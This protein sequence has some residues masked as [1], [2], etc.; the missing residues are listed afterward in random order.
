MVQP[1]LID[2]GLQ[3]SGGIEVSLDD[4]V[5]QP[6]TSAE[7]RLEEIFGHLGDLSQEL[8]ASD[9]L[10][11]N[12]S[13]DEGSLPPADSPEFEPLV[14]DAQEAVVSSEEPPRAPEPNPRPQVEEELWAAS[15]GQSISTADQL[16]DTLRAANGP[17]DSGEPAD[18]TWVLKNGEIL[19]GYGSPR[20]NLI[21]EAGIVSPGNSP[22][23]FDVDN[24]TQGAEGTQQIEITGWNATNTPVVYDQFIA[25]GNVTLDGT[26]K[27][28]LSGFTPAAGQTFSIM[29]WGGVRV[30]EFANYLGTTVP[31]NDQLAL[32]PEYDDGAKELRLRV[33]DTESVA[34][35]VERALRDV[36]ELAG[37]LLNLSA[38]GATSLPLIGS[39]IQDVLDAKQMVED[40]IQQ[41]ILN[42]VDGL[43]T[44]AQVTKE[45]EGLEGQTFGNFT[46]QVKSVLGQYSQPAAPNIFYAW[47]VKI[48]L[49]ET[50]L[51]ALLS[52]G[53]NSV[54]DFL[55]G[56][57]SQLTL[58]NTLELDFTFGYDDNDGDV[59]T[60]NAFVDLRSITPRTKAIASNLNPLQLTPAWLLSN[61]LT[62]I[63]ATATV[64]FEAWIQFAP[65]PNTFPG[66]H[67][68]STQPM[69]LPSFANFDQTEGSSLD[70][71]IVLNASVNDPNN[72]WAPFTF[73]KY[74]GQH[75]LHIVDT[76]LFDSVDPDVTLTV[77]GDLLVFGQK[78]T[79]VFTFFKAG[80]STDIAIDADI[81]NLDLKLT[82]GIGPELRILKATGTGNFLLK[83]NGDLAGV[84]SLTIAPGN[85]PELPNIDDLSGTFSLTFNGA[86]T[87]ITVPLPN[88]QSVIVPGGG[89]YYRIDGQNVTLDIGI[90]DIVLHADKFTFEPIDSTPANPNDD[91]QEIV[92]AV[93]GLS[94]DFTLPGDNTL[95][96]LTDGAGIL[97]LTRIG[98]E[99]GMVAQITSA[100]V[101]VDIFGIAGLTGQ[102]SAA[103]NDFTQAVNRQLNVLGQA[104][105][106][107][108]AA[109]KLLR[110]EATGAELSLLAGQIGDALQISGNFAFE[111][112]EDA[113]GKIVT[114]AFSQGH[115]PFLDGGAQQV[116]VLDNISGVF[117]SNEKG[118][119]GQAT[120]GTFQFGVP[121]I[122]FT[123]NPQSDISLQI[124]TTDE[125]VQ[126]TI[127]LG[128]QPV[129]L[130]VDTGPFIRFRMLQVN[131]TIAGFDVI[132]GDF[133]FE[134]RQS[135]SGQQMITVAAR[136]V[137]FNLGP[138][139]SILDIRDGNGLFVISG[140]QFAGAA[141]VIVDVAQAPW[142]TIDDGDPDPGIK[143]TF[144]FNNSTQAAIDQVF[145]FSGASFSGA[146]GGQQN[147]FNASSK[148]IGLAHARPGLAQPPQNVPVPG[149]GLVPLQVPA[150]EFFEV[151]G[152]I[153]LSFGAGGG[154]QTL[155]GVFAFTNVDSGGQKF[156]GVKAEDL[157]LQLK[158]GGTEVIAFRDG[159]GQFAL[160]N[161]GLGGTAS[162]DFELGIVNVGGSITLEVDS[163]NHPILAT[164]GGYNINLTET[165][166]L[167]VYVDG[168]IA[169]GPGSFPFDFDIEVDFVTNEV[170]FRQTGQPPAQFLVKVDA[171]GNIIFGTLPALP[172]FPQVGEGEFLPL[173]K[174]LINWLD[175]FRNSSVFDVGIPFTGGTTLGDAFDYAQW[176]ITNVYPEVASVEL[177]S[178]AS[179]RDVVGNPLPVGQL[180]LSGSYG[181]FTI[182]LEIGEDDPVAVNVPANTYTSAAQLATRLHSAVNPA[183]GGRVVGRLNKEGQP[184]L[185]LSDAEIAKH[186]TLILTFA[187]ANHP[188]T[189]LGFSNNQRAIEVERAAL[190]DM[191]QAVGQALGLSPPP[192]DPN[193]KVVTL[194]VNLNHNLPV[195][196]LPLDFG[197]SLGLIAEAT[198]TGNLAA[199]VNLKL[200]MTLGFDFS[201]VEVPIVLTSPLVPVPANGRL[202]ANAHFD[203]FLNGDPSPIGI[204]LIAAETAGFT[205]MEHLVNY[206][207]GKLAAKSYLG[208]PLDK[209]I[210][211]RK[212]DQ[213]I[214]LM[215]LQEDK[216]GDKHF[217]KA[218][219]DVNE[220]NQ[221][222][223]GEDL[224]GD[225][226]LDLNED[227][228]NNF[229]LDLGEDIDGDG[230][231]DRGED[232]NGDNAFQNRLGVINL[233]VVAA[234]ANN[235][236]ATELG[237][238]T[239]P[240]DVGGVSYLV[241]SAKS[242]LKGLFLDTPHFEATMTVSG[243]ATGKLRIGFLE[244]NVQPGTG[245]NTAPPIKVE[246]DIKNPNTGQTRFYIPELMNGLASLGNLVADLEVTGGVSAQLKLGLDPALGILL[247]SNAN[248]GILIPDIKD[249]SFNPEPYAPGKTGIFLTYTGLNG[250][251]SFSDV[252]FQ[253]ILQA[254]RA[255]VE[256]LSQL[257]GFGF[258]NEEIPFIEVSLADMLKWAEKVADLV[259]GLT[260]G[261][262]KSLQKMLSILQAEIESL[263]HINGRN[264]NIFSLIVDDVPNPLP[265]VVSGNVEATFNPAGGNNGLKF[266]SAGTSLSNA[267]IKI[268]GSSEASGG[269]AL[270]SWDATNQILTIKIDSGVTTA[271]AI[272]AALG[273]L[274]S[275]WTASLTEGGGTGLVNR[276]AIKVHLN[277]TTGF[278]HSVPLQINLQKLLG[279]L[280]GDNT[281]AHEFLSQAT[282]FIHLEGDGLLSV[283][284]SAGVVLD[285]GLDLTNPT[286]IKP[287]LYD[288]TKGS[289]KLEVIGT[290]LEFEA[291][292]GSV[293]GIFVR[294]G[295]VTL[296]ADGD[297]DTQG[298]AEIALGFKDNNGDGRHYFSE[299]LFDSESFGF[300]ARAGLTADLPV[301]A[302]TEGT[303]L[304]SD[305]D[306]N[307]DDYPDNHL[308]VDIPDLVRLFIPD[309]ANSPTATIEMR[310]NHNDFVVTSTDEAKDKFKV[311]FVHNP[312]APP[313]AQYAPG[314]NTLTL[315]INSGTTTANQILAEIATVPTFSAALTADDD[316]N[317][318][319][320]GNTGL[321]RL[322]KTTIATPDFSQLFSNLD[323]CAIIDQNAG[324]LL[325]GLD[326]A[327]GF[328]QDGLDDAVA[329]VDLP[330]IGDGLQGTANFIEDFREGLL[331][332]LRTA[333][334]QNGGSATET[335]KNAL[336][337][338]VWNVLGKPGADLLVDPV[339][340][341][342]LDTYQQIDI[343]LD[344][345]NGLQFNLRLHKALFAFDTGDALDID[346]G[347]PGFG[348]ELSGNLQLQLAFDF[349]LGFGLNKKDGFYFVTSAQP[350]LSQVN[351]DDV[352]SSAMGT[353]AE[354]FLGFSIVPQLAGSA[355]LFFLQLDVEDMGSFFRG[356]FEIDLKDP[357]N[358]GKLTFAELSSPGLSFGKVFVPRLGAVANV[359]LHAALS[360]GGSA[361]F[362]R[363]LANFHLD[364]SWDLEKG[365]DGPHINFDEI[366]LDLGSYIS[367]FLGPVLGKIREFTAPAD[368]ILD[369]VTEP[370]PII[371]DLLGEP[372]TFL[373]LAEAFGYLDPG[374]RKFIEV[375]AQV[376]DVIQLV[377]NFDGKSL[378]IPMG[379]FEMIAGI[380]NE[381]PRINPTGKL[382]NN[383]EQD[384]DSIKNANPGAG[385]TE[386]SQTVGFTGK[387]DASVF[388]F[389]IWEN[390]T[391]IFQ[392][393]IGAPVR[394][395]EVRLPT[396]RFEFTY[397]Q[398]IPIYGP[399]FAR[400]G[401]T[402]GAELTFGF[403]YD[404]FG[405]QKYISSEDK[406]VADIFDGFYI[407]DF[408]EAG[409]ERPEIRLFGEIFA[410]AQIDLGVA[411]AGVEGGVRVTVDFDLND[412]NDDGRIR[413]SE[414]IALAE[415][416]P[417]CLF[418]IHGTVDLFLRA[419]L[420]VNL[421]L[422]SIDAEWEFATITLF[423]FEFTCQLPEP[424]SQNGSVLTLHIGDDADQRKQLD[425]TDGAERFIVKHI[426]DDPGGETVEVNWEGF[427]EEFNGVQT[428]KVVNA[429]KGNDYID[430]RG[431][432]AA[433]DIKLGEG[434]DTILLGDG[435][436]KIDG[437]DG[438]DTITG[439]GAGLE[440]RGGAGRDTIVV[441]GTA[442]VY[443]DDG[444]DDITGSDGPDTIYGG[445]GNDR[446]VSGLDNDT[447]E[448]GSG[449][450]FIEAGLGDDTVRGDDGADEIRLGDGHDVAYGGN[451]D[452][453]ILGG[454]GN[455]V[456]IGGNGDDQLFGHSGVDLLVG[457]TV[458][459]WSP[460]PLPDFPQ[461]GVTVTGIGFEDLPAI[462]DP[463]QPTASHDDFLIGGGNYDFIFGGQGNDFIFGGN[464]FVSGQSEVIEEDDNDMMDGGTGDDE[465]FGDD[466]Q[467]KTGDRDTGIAVRSVVW[468]DQN[469]NHIRDEGEPGAAGVTVEIFTPSDP[470][471]TDKAVTKEDGSFKFTGLDPE[472][473]FLVFTSPY[474]PATQKGLRL[475]TPNLSENEAIDSDA[476]INKPELALL[477]KPVG[478]ANIGMT[479]TFTLHV[480]ETLTTVNAGV[481]GQ[482]VLSIQQDASASEG[483]TGTSPLN[484]T[485]NLSRAV[486]APVTVRF[487]TLDGTAK[488]VGAD[489]DY[490]GVN[491]VVTF[492]PGEKTKTVSIA[493]VG[494][495]VYE[496]RYEQFQ[497][498]LDQINAPANDPVY[499]TNGGQVSLSTTGTIIGD[500]GPPELSVSDYVPEDKGS[501][502]VQENTPATF[503]VRLSNPSADV[504]TVNWKTVDS[505]AFEAEGQAHYA[506][507]GTDYQP[508]GGALIFAPG[509]T[510]KTIGVNLLQDA[511]DE[512]EE[513][514]FVQLFNAHNALL[515]DNH[516]V[517]IIADD[518]GPVRVS[519]VLDPPNQV[520]GLPNTT[521]VF[522]GETALFK[523]RLSTASEKDVY[524]SY[525]SS[526]GTAVTALPLEVIFFTDQRP[527][528]ISAPDPSAQPAQQRLH[529]KPGET[530]KLLLVNTL[531]QD[532]APEPLE[533]FFLNLLTADNGVIA[534]NHGVIR[535]KDLDTGSGDAGISPI[536][537][538]KTHFYVH[539]YEPFAEITLVRSA[540]ST[541][542]TGVFFTQDVTATN[543]Q[544]Y[545]GGTY[546]VTFAPQEFVKTVQIPIQQDQVWEGDEDVK[547]SIRG[548]TGKAANAA[549]YVATLTILDDED[550]P[551]V[552]IS[553]PT[554]EVTEGNNVKAVFHLYSVVQA[555][556]IKIHYKTVD[557]TAF[558]GLDYTAQNSSVTLNVIVD[559]G[560]EGAIE[561]PILNNPALEAP[562]SFGLLLTGIEHGKLMQTKGTVIIRDDE[563]DTIEGYVFLDVN[564]NRFFDEF[565]E[566]GLKD[567][568]VAITDEDNNLFEFAVTDETGKYTA[569]A[570]QGRVSVKVLESSLT[571]KDPNQSKLKFYTGFELTTDNDSQTIE[572]LGGSGL[573]LFE[574][575][576]YQPKRLN[577]GRVD[578]PEPVG[579][580]G[581]D[582][583]LFG[584][585]G[586][587]FID[588]GAGDDHVVGGHWQTATNHWAP[589]NQ[590]SYDAKVKALFP[591]GSPDYT[592]LRPLNGLIFDVDTVG[593]GNNSTVSGSVLVSNNSLLLPY[594]GMN[595][596]LLDDKGNVVDTVKTTS[597]F[598]S[599]YTFDG[600]FPGK[601]Q[602]EFG[603]PEGYSASASVDPDTFRSPVFDLDD[604]AA[605]PDFSLNVTIQA[606]P[607]LPTSEQ[608]IFHKPT[609]IVAQGEQDSFAVVKLVRGEAGKREAVAV[610]T[611]ELN[612]PDAAQEN[613]HYKPIR[614]VVNFEIGQ[615]ERTVVVPILADG[616]IPECE[617]VELG[618]NLYAATGELLSNA[619]MFIQDVAGAIEDNDTIRGGDDWDII[620][621][622][623]G[624][625]P[626]HLHPG[627]FLDPAPGDPNPPPVLDPYLAIKFSGGPGEDSIDAGRNIDRVFGQGGEDFIDG[628]YGTDIIDAGLGNDLIAVSW[629][630][631]IVEGNF[632]RD[633]LEGT[634]DA[635]HLVEQGTG[636]GGE[637]LLKFDLPGVN[638]DTTITFTG[639]EHVK[640][641]GGVGNNHFTLTNWGGSAE[642]LGFFGADQLIV[643]NN[644]DMTLKDGIMEQLTLSSPVAK[645]ILPSVSTQAE[646]EDNPTKTVILG[647][648][649]SAPL[650]KLVGTSKAKTELGFLAAAKFIN[651]QPRASLT[652]G[653]GSLYTMTGVES[654][655]LI[656][657]PS[658][659]TLDAAQYSGN[660]IFQ[661]LGGDD[662]LLGGDGDDTFL[663]T[664]ADSGTDTVV[665]NAD[666]ASAANDQGF[667]TLDF[668]ALTQNLK[669]DLHILNA[670]QQIWTSG[671]LSLIFGDEDLDAILGGSGHD[672]LIGNARDNLLLGGIGN[673]RL[674][675]REGTE[676][677][678]FDA[679]LVWGTETVVED[680][681]D[682]SGHDVLDFSRTGSFAVV[683]DLNS[684][685]PQS[686]GNLT[687]VLGAGGFEEVIGGSLGDTLTGN[688]LD[689][690]LRGGPG[691]DTLFGLGGN[692]ILVGGPGFD[693]MIG[694][695][696]T[697]RLE[698]QANTHFTLNDSNLFKGDGDI[699]AL[700]SVED[701]HLTG[702]SS[703]NTFNLTGW[704]GQATLDAGGHVADRF[705]MQA[706]ADFDLLDLN[707]DDVRLEL[708]HPVTDGVADQTIDLIGFE[709]FELTGGETVDVLD[710]SALTANSDGQP[711]GAFT[712]AG[713]GGNDELHGTLWDDV[714]RGGPGND[715]L[716]GNTGN[717]DIDGGAGTDTLLIVRDAPLFLLLNSSILIDE[718]PL[719]DGS[720]LD[721]ITS[722][723]NLS[724]V[725]GPS[726]NIF[727]ASGWTGGTITVDGGGHTAG[728]TIKAAGDA[729]FTVTDSSI[730]IN[731]A[732]GIALTNIERAE[733]T[734]GPGDNI[735]DAS[736]FSGAVLMSGL[737]GNDELVAGTGTSILFGGDGDDILISGPG[738]TGIQGGQGDDTYIF[739]ADSPLGLDIIAD[740]GGTD[741]L[742]FSLTETVGI[743]LQLGNAAA[744][745]LNP[746]L[747]LQLLGA[748]PAFE[749]VIGTR[750]ADTITGNDLANRLE[751][752][753]GI[754]QLNG[755]NG[756]D[757]LVGGAGNDILAGGADNDTFEFDA[758]SPLGADQVSDSGGND[759]LDFSPTQGQSI[760]VTLVSTGVPQPVNANLSLTI[761]AGVQIE[762]VIGGN[763]ADNLTGNNLPNLIRGGLGEDIIDG[764]TGIDTIFETRDADF[765]LSNTQLRIGAEL[766]DLVSIEQAFLIG[767]AGDNIFDAG[768]FTLG[769]VGLSGLGGNDDLVGGSGADILLGG[770]G[771]DI[772]EGR[773]G[774]DVM[775]GGA[776]HDRYLFNLATPLG[777]DIIAELANGGADTLVGIQP[778]AINL[779]LN[780][781]QVISPN[782]TLT[783][784]NL[785]VENLEP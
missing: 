54:F 447:V 412:F 594:P 208:A 145:D 207:N 749:N 315:T 112:H 558:A 62:N 759:T 2:D 580:G 146:S 314:T 172:Q 114:V 768:T 253:Q 47:D 595:V 298:K 290:D 735:L 374:T 424:A 522:E 563:Q 582:D 648:A 239:D 113:N 727:D 81:S 566:R 502:P 209:W 67:W 95:L 149:D 137:E 513:R 261:N 454:S 466:A 259:D 421:L 102:F 275:P 537:F 352:S 754:D 742:D 155:S 335:I 477:G 442:T 115:L 771:D 57:G 659:N 638:F 15:H 351:T 189:A 527:D 529:F 521:E 701:A 519:L 746:N 676:T 661:G 358:D 782:L 556:D 570:S 371:S 757:V 107:S 211:A 508:A 318:N 391:E 590:G 770:D 201:A 226:R 214:A 230:L 168:F 237:I 420:R 683:L 130:N 634:R 199:T 496:G 401:G 461:D 510:E 498:L 84:A 628:G 88:D 44:Q 221:L 73:A 555:F 227:A 720:E 764:G 415:I 410:G 289:L 173:I 166:Y 564:G 134:Q 674:E 217:D 429:G 471:F 630:D 365:Q 53:L 675:G 121:A 245:F 150:G 321:G 730:T 417:L 13:T 105:T 687:L 491:T 493:L 706:A 376:V 532:T 157:T 110:V 602:L 702:G 665:G 714:L 395:I 600:V 357:N 677:Y 11:P 681:N 265:Q 90:P 1:S 419:F 118:L 753:A 655:H 452:D 784:Q 50:E 284:A 457:D 643:D 111:Q 269:L 612:G 709:L 647:T 406:N 103:I 236:A 443:G 760:T 194:P 469:G 777:A 453:L 25:S 273:T 604:T 38:P 276:T 752:G 242:S 743:V 669:V 213:S 605:N 615:Y 464:F 678:A 663:Y 17:P 251:E 206:I 692:D 390:P 196:N 517:G 671:P 258:L 337:Q 331:A 233:I 370:L 557:L 3:S 618:L 109:G 361:A 249:L 353:T 501:A 184:V 448:G 360:F 499:F 525:G 347:V 135:E 48:V 133:G 649:S 435:G 278:G 138:V 430:L 724:V 89:P 744:Q 170:I 309:Q 218:N 767:G 167:R 49:K 244:V 494:D 272:V 247:P 368:P 486:K 553:E 402:V 86:N 696:G 629:G 55:F 192:Y 538:A 398:K 260:S 455:D 500:D 79:G 543:G 85:G 212:A 271:N 633:V 80:A 779:A 680:P 41:E 603:V 745:V 585:P 333:I 495:P 690:T 220:N 187:G 99:S 231:L 66:G 297:P 738:N 180:P 291:S 341:A 312:A 241:S 65:N 776:G 76:D 266:S 413:I 142:L 586:N 178:V 151:K 524:V 733:L 158:A 773:G 366:Y 78:L 268:L 34:V 504:V 725:G 483:E 668:T 573:E 197:E 56:A 215:A 274:G 515:A 465:L 232:L 431:T 117:V 77:D 460:K 721:T 119:A 601:Y 156:V 748:T 94:F 70:A 219:E 300:T 484:V 422:F 728:D 542:A 254:L 188:M 222:D 71:T 697:D 24:Y 731:G 203:L 624:Y 712:L 310:G 348:L 534:Q 392:L 185:A 28:A 204:D 536:S 123:T 589:I 100:Q 547:L 52:S 587:D 488:S 19:G 63:S 512:Y 478:Q 653:N 597:A 303:P 762:N 432:T 400:F 781:A 658:A 607:Q 6:A 425:T 637:D 127:S 684:G 350:N 147:G 18:A 338:V 614:V 528:F 16:T 672:D 673:D 481:V 22:G 698:E 325:D 256:M 26:L 473:Y 596:N 705:I 468:L 723:E 255:V 437:G 116:L 463:G 505:A 506:T 688:G 344:C 246:L 588:A 408:D 439:G 238:G 224:D 632:D 228:N 120:V 152:P 682:P 125:P 485:L 533:T 650:S 761:P 490:V 559:G 195:L 708:D 283:A 574:P 82:V 446:I 467:G 311:V 654:S 336:K 69:N 766:D 550:V 387:L 535:V 739:D 611:E 159:V 29:Q 626:K 785:N 625:I 257:Q 475:V 565:T 101:D 571:V 327:L 124:N 734:G 561:I 136:D 450:D 606:G 128:G 313:D 229:M 703:A 183:T 323:L 306:A 635:D 163:T 691:N 662:Q 736:Q 179:F 286:G 45:I 560:S 518:D 470:T 140:G 686:I 281:A 198:L 440:I 379:A 772:L 456:L 619:R 277:F 104:K 296:D 660:V 98:N 343:Q 381:T 51:T 380:G 93:E 32:V 620:L 642:I 328:I 539:E 4:P 330:L 58:E 482:V 165:N 340:G 8:P 139:S 141:E 487:R 388:H 636:P 132:T 234:Q 459:N 710:G 591:E 359:D 656:G 262:P 621:G 664:A 641:L 554:I 715:T 20:L 97:L 383:F 497:I 293:V 722:V 441:F 700:E 31:G 160:F 404:T 225:G 126:K 449:N 280:V 438:D 250:I 750:V 756:S 544:D 551:E 645:L 235:P 355:E 27:I 216:D 384:L 704:T 326:K 434:N 396:F 503:T 445:G 423:E 418:N 35:E 751:G 176:F 474:N 694:G 583:T 613:V 169:V 399:L 378:L 287:F 294:D 646:S 783:L 21:N 243:S 741:T 514:F 511:I 362:P 299:A 623:S 14:D 530:E 608:V 598:P 175:Q 631:D 567:V 282:S 30:G 576:G 489:R 578:G 666:G 60:P 679:D 40:T 397:V 479:E 546:I 210:I 458:Q 385:G 552:Y 572:F 364:W 765:I 91:E 64:I 758:D 68:L 389:P 711:R 386:V 592:L 12:E 695:D 492:E 9:P 652:L 416:D 320:T 43:T 42:L 444:A 689:N 329:A 200:A 144:N 108:V 732:A 627:R 83:D 394:L 10:P 775:G 304:G 61:P 288:T 339:T 372:I 568:V 651:N 382:L 436:G 202:S 270:A 75:T 763:Q 369:M 393:F 143:M 153:S 713:G 354:L 186:S 644:T 617:S 472:K 780:T 507:T 426:S 526:Q 264:Q 363:V 640:L 579:R 319:T 540:G 707:A 324:L 92:V 74:S 403:G 367:E 562:E 106:L 548:F 575:I 685:A 451:G 87:P 407:I 148:A 292:L 667:D 302:P 778:A 345:D 23:V 737:G 584:G 96:S 39:S 377:G 755:A 609:Y 476:D 174:Q 405:I 531:D 610:I 541:S 193:K 161:D 162:L 171:N 301:Y 670:P 305:G 411:E 36:A 263:F 509:Q 520:P 7:S 719:T 616:P 33:V 622:D 154:T 279:R 545:T 747:T 516:G 716:D 334:A 129:V 346:I 191:I 308:V 356:G 131:L 295:S 317:P 729:D 718:D 252:S 190:G 657:G 577:L 581:T 409:N 332:D 223:P 5:A 164:Q 316:G 693:T 72:L 375:V 740:L 307:N 267:R 373:D 523:V 414:L 569:H 349:K 699:E 549:P 593:M 322:V 181:A 769:R 717:D 480:N 177:R 726:D 37:N 433:V 774:N 285:F 342:S 428:I 205:R 46:V 462:A 122:G 248:I 599:N 639:I 240:I 182:Q 59:L 427:V